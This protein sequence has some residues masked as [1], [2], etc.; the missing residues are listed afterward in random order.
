MASLKNRVATPGFHGSPTPGLV[1]LIP[2]V[3]SPGLNGVVAKTFN[4]LGVWVTS[5][6]D[7][8]TIYGDHIYE[9]EIP[10][11]RYLK[12]SGRVNFERTF[13]SSELAEKYFPATLKKM[14]FGGSSDTPEN[15]ASRSAFDYLTG[16]FGAGHPIDDFNP[17]GWSRTNIDRYMF[18]AKSIMN[19]LIDG[20][21]R[22]WKYLQAW[23]ASVI[24]AGYDGILWPNSNIDVGPDKGPHDV[25]LIWSDLPVIK[26]ATKKARVGSSMKTTVEKLIRPYVNLPLECDGMTRVA[27]YVLR[28]AGIPVMAFTGRVEIP[29]KNRDFEPHYWLVLSTGEVVDYKLRMW[30]GRAG[31][32][33][34]VFK[35]EDEGVVYHGRPTPLP[36]NDF[37][38]T[39][40]TLN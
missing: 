39:V 19:G 8:A 28:K 7:C 33:N 9:V 36:V 20:M 4:S 15:I 30:F 14:L 2:G 31:I 12:M 10:D 27:A 5:N 25:Y 11:G 35:P 40:L 23:R 18:V 6:R 3:G 24:A 29:A 34:G 26:E 16:E 1:K 32:P 13:F 22:N 38:F 17:R 37:L 21:F